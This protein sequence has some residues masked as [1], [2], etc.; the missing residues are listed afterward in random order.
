MLQLPLTQICMYVCIHIYSLDNIFPKHLICNWIS[1]EHLRFYIQL[2]VI[3][4]NYA[5]HQSFC[6][7]NQTSMD[8]WL[9]NCFL[10]NQWTLYSSYP[11]QQ[12]SFHIL[13]LTLVFPA[14]C[15]ILPKGFMQSTLIFHFLKMFIMTHKLDFLTY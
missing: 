13:T 9:K 12:I 14:T 10:S 7:E 3:I 6:Y 4:Y 1:V 11:L 8:K 2:Q 5:A 15:T